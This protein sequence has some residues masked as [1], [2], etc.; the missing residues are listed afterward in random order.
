MMSLYVEERKI[1][2]LHW[3]TI[4]ATMA[5]A[6]LGVWNLASASQS[7]SSPL[8]I[9]QLTWLGLGSLVVA[10]SLFVDYKVLR[11]FAWPV[12]LSTVVMLVL[13][14]VKGRVIMGAQRWLEIGPV[15]LQPS[16]FAKLSVI[17]ML[18]R[19]FGESP[20]EDRVLRGPTLVERLFGPLLRTWS[21]FRA[22]RRGS[23][24]PPPRMHKPRARRV[25][26]YTMGELWWPF[27]LAG[28]PIIIVV[29]QPDLGTGLVTAAVAGSI[30]LFA[31]LRARTLVFLGVT[32]VT[33][34]ILAWFFALKQYQKDRVMTFLDPAG[35][36]QGKG[37]HALQ[38]IIA[39][40]SGRSWGKGWGNGT[41]NQLAFL[42]EQHTDFAFPVWAEEHGFAG[43]IIAVVLYLFLVFCALDVVS[44]ARD[45]FG[46][47]LAFGVGALFFWHAFINIGM[48]IGVLPVVGVPLLLFSYGGSSAVLTLLGIG[49]LLNV[50][51]R[52]TQFQ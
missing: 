19:Y 26:G 34:A 1:G 29:K 24:A 18:A 3:P 31:G 40:G 4:I 2:R 5:I 41:Q 36:A 49:V 48:V 51:L 7:E 17:L 22:R 44:N 52:R 10:A 46:A 11:D 6:G 21:S 43:A 16:E 12:Y 14:A 42:P 15:R 20:A 28:I 45:R 13:V 37:Y 30:V 33:G 25:T 9:A 8:W 35:D 27:L 50:S 23:F 39:V 38:S 47:F 32:G